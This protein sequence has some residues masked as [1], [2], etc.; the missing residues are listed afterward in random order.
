MIRAFSRTRVLKGPGRSD[1]DLAMTKWWGKKRPAEGQITK[2]IS[3]H[4]QFVVGPWLKTF[5][6][7]II[8]R[9]P[10]YIVYPGGALLLTYGSIQYA[11]A[12]TAADDY[13][14]RP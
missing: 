11:G 8:R 9:A 5:P 3:A 13:S 1:V 12:L 6:A 7:K 10:V 14:H 4:E 2:S